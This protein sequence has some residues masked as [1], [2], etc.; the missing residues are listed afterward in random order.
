MTKKISQR[1]ARQ[2]KKRA[3]A[4]ENI[5]ER[6]KS[7][8]AQEWPNGIDLGSIP[9]GDGIYWSA[10]TARKLGRSVFVTCPDNN[11]IRLFASR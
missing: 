9:V 7:A 8:Y 2:W 6:Q 4:A 11:R 1:E 10:Q 3:L 5:L